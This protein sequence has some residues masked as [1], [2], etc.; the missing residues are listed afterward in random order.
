MRLLHVFKVEAFMTIR[1]SSTT[2]LIPIALLFLLPASALTASLLDSNDS[3]LLP[4][5]TPILVRPVKPVSSETARIGDTVDFQVTRDITIDGVVVIPRG[6][7]AQGIVVEAMS[8][9]E[10][11]MGR[12]GVSVIWASTPTGLSVPVQGMPE[13][14]QEE[15]THAALVSPE[16]TVVTKTSIDVYLERSAYV[17]HS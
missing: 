8:A 17:K 13:V 11:G 10:W 16:S 14:S 6:S 9:K 7:K 12:L 1:R 15:N 2:L 4:Q 5:G 3:L